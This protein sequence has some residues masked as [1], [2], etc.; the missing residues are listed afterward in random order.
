[1]GDEKHQGTSEKHQD[2]PSYSL[3]CGIAGVK[4]CRSGA[5]SRSRSVGEAPIVK[6]P[7][8]GLRSKGWTTNAASQAMRLRR[9]KNVVVMN[10]YRLR[11]QEFI[12]KRN[13]TSNYDNYD[14]GKKMEKLKEYETATRLSRMS[15]QTYF[16]QKRKKKCAKKK[17]KKT[18]ERRTIKCRTLLL[19]RGPLKREKKEK[20]EEE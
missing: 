17:K 16:C 10:I 14:R 3:E 19:E 13:A 9:T 5:A 15:K 20:E 12:S 6:T 4:G 1:M 8:N 2:R 7:L 11:Y 18:A